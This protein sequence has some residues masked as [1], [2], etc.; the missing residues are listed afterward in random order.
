VLPQT[1]PQA[2]IHII[3]PANTSS[4]KTLL[5]SDDESFGDLPKRI[6]EYLSGKQV[7]FSDKLDL[8]GYSPFQRKVWEKEKTIPYGETRTYQWLA[9]ALGYPHAARAVGNALA[10][11][12]LPI[13]IPC[14]RVIR[15]DGNLGGFSGGVQL[16]RALLQM[17]ARG[18]QHGSML[19]R[20][21]AA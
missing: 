7:T 3:A 2:V 13:L 15:S 6:T 5:P 21:K 9:T 19:A 16:K 18:N 8:S 10:K 12:P 1:S 20:N 4:N 17:E 14:H 11:N